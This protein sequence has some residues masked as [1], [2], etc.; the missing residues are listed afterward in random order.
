MAV[1]SYGRA[2]SHRRYTSS[3]NRALRILTAING[4]ARIERISPESISRYAFSQRADRGDA[5]TLFGISRHNNN[6]D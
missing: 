3:R 4:A 1:I 2:G 6:R 5:D